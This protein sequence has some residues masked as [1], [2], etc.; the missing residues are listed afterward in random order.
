MSD[1]VKDWKKALAELTPEEQEACQRDLALYG[2]AFID[3]AAKRRI[4]AEEV[5]SDPSDTEPDCDGAQGPVSRRRS[6]A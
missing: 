2:S 3:R 4:P 5:L 1:D 6:D